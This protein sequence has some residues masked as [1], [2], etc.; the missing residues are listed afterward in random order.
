[1]LGCPQSWGWE[2][3]SN[4]LPPEVSREYNIPIKLEFDHSGLLQKRLLS[5]EHS[6][7]FASVDM[8]NPTALMKANRSSPVVNFIR[9]KMC[10]I[11]KP[12]LK[13][14]PNNL[15]DWM[16]NPEIRLGTST[17]NEDTSGDYAQEIF[18]KAEKVQAG[19]FNELN[20]K[21]LR[22]IGGRNSPVVP[23]GKNEIAYFITETQ[24]V[25]IFLSYRTDAR[26]AVLAASSMQIV[27][28]PENLA[29]KANYGMTLMKDARS[30]GVMLAMYILSQNGQKILTK[31]GFDS[32]LIL[33]N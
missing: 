19:S 30:S 24:Q 16:L 6:D 13:V 27:E 26:L 17:P 22:L 33:D 18:H 29:V 15:L 1:M 3:L 7:I 8:E 9:N 25:D 12:S 14:T 4:A 11:V 5:G 31:Y 10:A 23:K 28:L 32:P 20:R 21:A 2:K